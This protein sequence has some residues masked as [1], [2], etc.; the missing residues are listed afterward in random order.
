MD[1]DQE[2][3]HSQQLL[4]ITSRAFLRLSFLGEKNERDGNMHSFAGG[5]FST[6]SV[7]HRPT[8]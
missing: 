4:L 2:A 8:L 6:L 7:H 5:V 3:I 1:E